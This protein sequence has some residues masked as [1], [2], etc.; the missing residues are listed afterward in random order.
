MVVAVRRRQS[1]LGH[2]QCIAGGTRT[3][4]FTSQVLYNSVEEICSAVIWA[5]IKGQTILKANHGV[6]NSPKKRTLG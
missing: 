5:D 1:L 3:Q 4:S 2:V 6:L